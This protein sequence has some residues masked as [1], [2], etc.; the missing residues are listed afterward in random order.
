[1]SNT[2]LSNRAVLRLSGE[3]VRDFLQGIVTNDMALLAPGKPL[4]A[5]LLAAQGKVLFDFILWAEDGDVLVDCEAGRADELARRLTLYRLRRP[6]NIARDETLV[7]HWSGSGGQGDADPRLAARGQ[8][9]LA[10]ADGPGEGYDAHRMALGVAE[11]AAELGVDK[12]LWLEA[13]AVELNGVSFTKGCYVGQENT[14]RMH[15]RDKVRRRMMPVRLAGDPGDET[16]LRT[17]DG[18]AAGELRAAVGN[19]GIAWLRMEQADTVLAVGNAEA[20][21]I[22][23]EWLNDEPAA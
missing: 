17:P 11:G 9:G 16:G 14:A 13:N 10:G 23:P 5:A 2:T 3:G 18:K 15:H 8:R 4:W 20:E 21:V 7:V 19:T 12:T 22:W 1:M 6:I